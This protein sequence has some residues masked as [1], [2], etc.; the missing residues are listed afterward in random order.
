ME[1]LRSTEIL[2]KEIQ[3]D[4]RRKAERILKDADD[5]CTRMMADVEDRIQKGRDARKASYDEKLAAKRRDSEAAIPL[6]KQRFLISFEN[7]AV[8][9][10]CAAYLA[11][12]KPAQK[13]ELI[14]K[15]LDQKKTVLK[16]R[17]FNAQVCGF[18]ISAVKKMLEAGLGAKSILSCVEA[19]VNCIK[20]AGGTF[21]GCLLESDDRAVKCRLTIAE[22]IDGI[23]DTQREELVAALF[24]G[25]LP[26]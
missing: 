15:L 1:E 21:E 25:R 2:D 3:E 22:I 23:A 10:A 12:L 16:D 26:E 19:D 8:Q 24:A 6:E 18:D 13:L 11:A 9:D 4:A 7:S 20:A 14:E 5:E 17:K